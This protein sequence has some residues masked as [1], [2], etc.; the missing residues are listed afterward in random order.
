MITE[1]DINIYREELSR[2]VIDAFFKRSISEEG[3]DTALRVM[4]ADMPSFDSYTVK[5]P[6]MTVEDQKSSGR[7][8]IYAAC[9][10]LRR[11]FVREYNAKDILFSQE[12]VAFFDLLEKSESFLEFVIST[13]DAPADERILWEKLF[14]PVV[15]AGQWEFFINII[16]KYGLVTQDAMQKNAQTESTSDMLWRL[17]DMLRA[18][19]V[20]IRKSYEAGGTRDELTYL[21]KRRMSDV[22]RFLSLCMG[23]PPTTFE[24]K[25]AD[26]NGCCHNGGVLTPKEFYA[27]YIKRIELEQSIV[28][29]CVDG[30]GMSYGKGYYINDLSNVQEKRP[31]RY[32]NIRQRDLKKLVRTQLEKG[33][34][35]WFGC[36]SR[37]GVD[38]ENGF[39]NSDCYDYRQIGLEYPDRI[40]RLSSRISCLSH[41]MVFEGFRENEEGVITGWLVK[42]SYGDRK[43]HHGYL[44]MADRWFDEYVYEAV[45]RKEYLT[46]ELIRTYEDESNL[47]ELPP[48][49]PMGSLAD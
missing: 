35:V 45:I 37:Y 38:K 23:E 5:L 14:H 36:D 47:I 12:Y 18:A 28:V 30:C 40:S 29:T 10:V 48:W 31:V 19:A 46:S 39:L 2:N 49:H 7:C 41:S 3:I 1:A 17:S 13:A 44:D 16:E 33:Y 25:Y 26:K 27:K 11:L 43:G 32:L 21:K 9:H 22:Y 24:F 15:D 6:Q 8:W 4:L 42:N 20:E 34:A